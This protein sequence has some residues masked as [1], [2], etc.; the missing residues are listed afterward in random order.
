MFSVKITNVRVKNKKK[1][2]KGKRVKFIDP[3]YGIGLKC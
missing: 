2:Q 1:K 3:G